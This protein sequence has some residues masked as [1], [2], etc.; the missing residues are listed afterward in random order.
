MG[1][2]TDTEGL[3]TNWENGNDRPDLDDFNRPTHSR[4]LGPDGEPLAYREFKFGFQPPRKRKK[5]T[6]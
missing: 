2:D 3:E 4:L 6:N 5:R 1:A